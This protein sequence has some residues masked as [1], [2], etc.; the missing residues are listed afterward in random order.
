MKIILG[1]ARGSF[2]VSRP[3]KTRYGGQTFSLLIEGDD[4]T[5][6]L[7]DAGTGLTNLKPYWRAGGTVC[8]THTHL[9][10]ILALPFLMDAWPRQL[11]LPRGD[12]PDVLKRVFAPPT[13]PVPLPPADFTIPPQPA[14]IGGLQLAWHEVAHPDGCVA[15]RVEEPA[16][17]AA[18]VIVSDIEWPLMTA[19]AQDSFLAFAKRADLLIFDAHFLPEEYEMHRNWGHST[20]EDAIAVAEQC[21]ARQLWLAHHAPQ[22]TDD[23][24]DALNVALRE[25]HPAAQYVRAGTV[26][27]LPL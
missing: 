13:W 8:F 2:P 6:I 26:A 17:G 15:Y 10:H 21:Q 7:V 14:R 18:V 4:G 5:Q 11:I 24:L 20:W 22:R 16:S 23:E 25:R 9:D 12:L 19:K 27:T 3:D 1:G